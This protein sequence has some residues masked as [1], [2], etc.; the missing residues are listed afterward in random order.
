V[1]TPGCP[2]DTESATLRIPTPGNEGRFARF[3][4]ISW[5]DQQRLARAK[6]LV[7]GAG[8]LGNEILKNLALIGAGRVLVADMD[9][10][11]NSNLSRSVLY[12]AE[13]CGQFKAEVACRAARELY[14]EMRVEP[15][16]G[17]VVHDLGWG[18]YLWADVIIGGL[19][20]REARVAI[21]SASRYAGRTWIDGAIEVLNGVTRVFAPSGPCYECTMNPTDWKMIEERRSCALLSR[22]EMNEG[23]VPTTPTTASMIAGLQVQEA[24]KIL[25]GLDP[26][27]GKGFVLNG[28]SGESYLVQYPEKP[29]CDA[30]ERYERLERL[31][32][33]VADVTIGALLERAAKDL[34]G[35][36]VID[37]RRDVI[38]ALAC[39]S[40]GQRDEIFR[41]LGAVTEEEGR[42]PKCR[43]M[44][45]PELLHTLGL[46]PG[47]E[48]RTFAD[49]GVPPFD[50]V[51]ARKGESTITYLFEGDAPAVLRSLR[52]E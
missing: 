40:C 50:G 10:I 1:S 33:G 23:K 26:I 9:R 49:I 51:T 47:L 2:P 27:A 6:I 42:C 38:S 4:L 21:N 28:L 14:P 32:D 20:N 43:T 46:E 7:I 39:P 41:S 45:A 30:H 29:D 35:Q 22:E 24:L 34:S 16:V 36:A 19:D 31:P 48:E 15:F 8:A 13:D 5:W 17:N 3:E 44:R 18:V 52:E 11:E 12:R 37:L 25:H